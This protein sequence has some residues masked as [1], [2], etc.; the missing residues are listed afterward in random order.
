[1]K[2]FIDVDRALGSQSA[3]VGV[4]P[5]GLQREGAVGVEGTGPGATWSRIPPALAD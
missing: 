1:L 4:L 2:T 5:S 3:H